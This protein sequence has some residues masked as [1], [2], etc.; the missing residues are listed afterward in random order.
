MKQ[1]QWI[2]A[3]ALLVVMVFGITFA[4][5]YLG[6]SPKTPEPRRPP[7]E[8]DLELTF[9][10]KQFPPEGVPPTEQELGT[11]GYQDFWFV[12]EESKDVNIWLNTTT[13]K[14]SHVMLFV[15]P[16]EWV[17][18]RSLLEA[19]RVA[20][21]S[22][23]PWSGLGLVMGAEMDPELPKLLK[24][25]KGTT[26]E[27]DNK[28]NKATVPAGAAGWL[29]LAWNGERQ[30]AAVT[31]LSAEVWMD[32][33]NTGPTA[34]LEAGV[35]F[36]PPLRVLSADQTRRLGEINPAS[37]PREEGITFWSSTRD[38]LKVT[39]RMISR[40]NMPE[41]DPFVVGQPTPL[42]EEER[43]KLQKRVQAA[44]EP[45]K[46]RCAYRVPI[47][48]RDRSADGKTQLDIGPFN[49][50]V[51]LTLDDQIHQV[52]VTLNGAIQ[53]DLTVGEAGEGGRINFGTFT[54]AK[55]S[56]PIIVPVWTD[57]PSL[58]GLEL[59][60][61]RTADFLEV[62]ISKPEKEEGGR[63]NWKLTAVIPPGAIGGPFPFVE[64]PDRRDCAVY[65]KTIGATGRTIRIPV[66]G[67]AN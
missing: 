56:K 15:A 47:Q 21:S 32:R 63:R 55:G 40:R 4:L 27:K 49:R 1:S 66:F 53:G 31:K 29:R 42:T 52:A 6:D 3:L 67:L 9:G 60:R 45:G 5:Q 30:N 43:E 64:N 22:L 25:I 20:A 37:L 26:L 62:K 65:L 44:K 8:V 19:G 28:D 35:Q 34:R 54:G 13:C 11:D 38:Q 59:D 39:A 23:N 10:M 33:K 36:L 16:R 41:S 57:N 18:R 48:I 24:E 2:M 58:E 46:V 14:C 17:E 51:E 12:N 7:G 61:A 50:Q